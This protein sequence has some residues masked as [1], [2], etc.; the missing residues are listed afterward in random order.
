M[1]TTTTIT[2]VKT[3]PA[4]DVS[5]AGVN[6]HTVRTTDID[7]SK[8]HRV[9]DMQVLVLGLGRT[10]TSCKYPSNEPFDRR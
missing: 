4:G 3:A 9:K 5:L 6:D 8:C 1:S 2:E 10:G 7:R